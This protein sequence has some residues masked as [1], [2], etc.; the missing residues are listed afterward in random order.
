MWLKISFR[1]DGSFKMPTKIFWMKFW[2]EHFNHDDEHQPE[3]VNYVLLNT[4]FCLWCFIL[5]LF[6]AKMLVFASGV[7]Y[8]CCFWIR[9]WFEE[10]HINWKRP[11]Y[12][13]TSKN[14]FIC[15]VTF[16]RSCSSV[17]FTSFI[18]ETITFYWPKFKTERTNEKSLLRKQIK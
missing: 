8:C 15:F 4:F 2:F 11:E 16:H 17:C 1:P 5:L 10:K 7:L 13:S 14:L 12:S 3:R 18:F 9:C 6:L